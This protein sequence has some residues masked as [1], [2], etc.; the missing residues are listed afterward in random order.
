MKDRAVGVKCNDRCVL[1]AASGIL[2]NRHA[3]I[4]QYQFQNLNI[5]Q[6]IRLF[7]KCLY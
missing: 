4:R 6:H 7:E 5:Q 2:N 3:V 1:T